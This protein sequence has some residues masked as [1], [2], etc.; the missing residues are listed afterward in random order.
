MT[1]IEKSP[2]RE[3]SVEFLK[4]PSFQKKP[5]DSGSYVNKSDLGFQGHENHA[6]LTQFTLSLEKNKK[7]H[8]FFIT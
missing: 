4:P 3:K 5:G 8:K 2:L 6:F 7:L 1:T